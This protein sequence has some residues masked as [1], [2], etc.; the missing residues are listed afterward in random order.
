MS[1][2]RRAE[3]AAKLRGRSN[4]FA[5][6]MKLA[7]QTT[8]SMGSGICSHVKIRALVCSWTITRSSCRNFQ[9]SWLVPLSTAR[10]E[11]HTSELQSIMRITYA[12]FCLKTK[13]ETTSS[14][15]DQIPSHI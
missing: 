3:G 12:V 13:N 14:E 7:S 5:S 9:A 1:A 6:E 8:R 11:E 2:I 10:S 4:T 15:H